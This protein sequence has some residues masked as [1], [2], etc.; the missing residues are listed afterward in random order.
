M[1][2]LAHLVDRLPQRPPFRFVD[3][4]V[5]LDPLRSAVGR[6]TFPTGHRVFEGH[7]PGDPIV[8][9][10][11]LI[12]AL[13][14]LSGICLLRDGESAVRG[15]LADVGRMR[16]RRLVRPDERVTLR[17]ELV[18]AFGSTARFE[19]ESAVDGERACEGV[20]TIGGAELAAG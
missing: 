5:E 3:A 18:R 8:P 7:L 12:E 20:L 11:I 9:G 16:F 4:V 1:T 14:Q 10:V 6:V 17:S 15:F 19:V 2:T 13:A